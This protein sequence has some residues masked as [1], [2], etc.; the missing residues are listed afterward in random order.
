L[1]LFREKIVIVCAAALFGFAVVARASS[2]IDAD[3]GAKPAAETKSSPLGALG[4]G[5]TY[6]YA[7]VGAGERE[8]INGWYARPS[9]NLPRKYSLFADF[10]NYYGTTKKGSLNSHGDTF[11]IAKQVIT[12][13]RI[14]SSVFAESGVVRTSNGGSVVNQFAF[15]AGFNLSIP[16]NKHMDFTMTPA[17]WI[18]LYPK[19]DP[20]N[21]YNAKVGVSFPFGRR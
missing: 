20:R 19:G 11:G 10:T 13:K 5:W 14:K 2:P 18:F 3:S 17:E 9:I 8:S 4:I 6:I 1:T 12:A 15:N 16:V 21:D 7:D